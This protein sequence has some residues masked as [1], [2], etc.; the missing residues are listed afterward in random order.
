MSDWIHRIVVSADINI[1]FLTIPFLFPLALCFLVKS[2]NCLIIFSF[3]VLQYSFPSFC[4]GLRTFPRISKTSGVWHTC[5]QLHL[6]WKRLYLW[7]W[8]IISLH[9][10]TLPGYHLSP[11]V[12]TCSIFRNIL[13]LSFTVNGDFSSESF[14]PSQLDNGFEGLVYIFIETS[15]QRFSA[16]AA[17]WITWELSKAP[18]SGPTPSHWS[19]EF[20]KFPGWCKC[21]D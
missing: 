20:W 10:H 6:D 8:A 5:S 17:H 1:L 18:Y 12:N 19:Q 9:F 16:W 15:W 13:G 3:S 7:H 21:T 4:T 11:I 14:N 2:I